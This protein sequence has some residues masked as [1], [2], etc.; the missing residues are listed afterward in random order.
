MC[1][2]GDVQVAKFYHLFALPK[3]HVTLRACKDGGYREKGLMRERNNKSNFSE[4]AK[5]HF[6]EFALAM[7]FCQ[8]HFFIP[9]DACGT[10]AVKIRFGCTQNCKASQ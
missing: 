7:R 10:L 1:I 5:K 3:Y 9:W 8:T 6:R 2:M 4:A